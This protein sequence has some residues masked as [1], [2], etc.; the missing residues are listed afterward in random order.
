MIVSS[1]TWIGAR[2]IA[3]ETSP[4]KEIE[5]R[6]KH[7][8]LELLYNGNIVDQLSVRLPSATRGGN[9]TEVQERRLSDPHQAPA[10]QYTLRNAATGV[11][12]DHA[13]GC[14]RP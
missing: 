1:L 6:T 12:C 14:V 2:W 3:G 8:M 11:A 9:I 13:G 4:L 10:Q 5:G 7:A